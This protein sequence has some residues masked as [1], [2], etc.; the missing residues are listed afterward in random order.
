MAQVASHPEFG[1]TM[2]QMSA[3][4][5]LKK[6]GHKAEEALLAEF[7]QLED[8]KVYEPL[9]P[10]K[11]TRA[12]KK[13][14]LRAINL[15]KDKRC[16]RLKGGTVADG[17]T[18]EGLYDKSETASPTIATDPLMVSIIVDAFERRDVATADIAGAYLK[19]YMEDFTIMK[20]MGPSV[21][22]LCSMKP[23]YAKYVPIKNGGKVL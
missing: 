9:G 13:A 1:I 3:K 19:A 18:Q 21:D 11:L 6:H 4:A 14:A 2:T 15:I 8:L 7:S 20:F 17:Q 12:Q 10:T 5:G 16:G 22:I 23:G